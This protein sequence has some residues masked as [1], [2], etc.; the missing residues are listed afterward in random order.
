M[1][2]GQR[3]D[4]WSINPTTGDFDNVGVG[5][6]SD[7]GAVVETIEG[8]IRNSSWHFLR[9]STRKSRRNPED[10]VRNEDKRCPD[11]QVKGV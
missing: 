10:D 1:H 9:S 11:C 2:Q 3:L 5:R 8:G 6:V 4:L 7:D